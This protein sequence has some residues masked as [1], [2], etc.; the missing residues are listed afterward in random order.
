MSSLESIYSASARH[1]DGVYASYKLDDLPFY[2]ELAA[3]HGG[4]ILELGAGTGRVT[5]PLARAGHQVTALDINPAMLSQLDT[6]LAQEPSDVR[7]RV[8]TVIGSMVDFK[9]EQRFSMILMPFRGF[10]HLLDPADQRACLKNLAAHL[11]DEGRYVFDAYNPNFEF[12]VKKA[13]LGGAFVPDLEYVDADG[14]TVRRFNSI[15]PHFP[16]QCSTVLFRYETSDSAGRLLQIE[17]DRIHMRW[18]SRWE[19]QYLLE[20]S[21]LEVEAAYGGF[22]RRSLD[23]PGTELIYVCRRAG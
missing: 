12:L 15:T 8:S 21:G 14:N 3:R 22:D 16:T 1:Y 20:L 7:A 10:Q 4:P 17:V 2:L 9:L 5:I 23:V 19:A 6:K 11:A 18:Q 13:G